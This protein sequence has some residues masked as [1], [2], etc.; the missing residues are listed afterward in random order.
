MNTDS[1]ALEPYALEPIGVPV[2]F[3]GVPSLAGG[4]R[5]LYGE[6]LDPF[7][8]PNSGGLFVFDTVADD[9][10]A[11]LPDERHA[12]FRNV[13]VHEDSAM[14]A[15][16]DGS[17]LRYEPGATTLRP[18]GISLGDRL[19]AS[20]RPDSSGII[21]AVTTSQHDLVA[22]D[23]DG[24]VR[25][26]GNA[27]AYSTSIALLPDQSAFIYVPDAHGGTANFGAP[28]IAV[29][30]S[31]GVQTTL[32]ELDQLARDG[33]GLV[34]GGSFN[35]TVDPTRRLAH[36]GLNAGPTQESPWG[37]VVQITV[38]LDNQLAD[39]PA[40]NAAA[41]SLEAATDTFGL[42]APLTGIRGHAV[43]VADIN[44]D[45]W[46]D[47]FVGTFA[48]RPPE[49]YAVRGAQGPNPDRLLLGGPDGF[50]LDDTFPG[51]LARSA[52]AAF[53]DLDGDGD[54]DVIS[55][56]LGDDKVAWYSN[57]AGQFGP[58]QIITLN[59]DLV[60]SV[61][62]A[63]V[64]ADG[65][66]DVISVSALDDKVA[67]YQGNGAGSFGPEQIISTNPDYPVA[68]TTADLDGDLDP[69]VITASTGDDTLAWFENET[70]FPD[71]N[72]NGVNDIVEIYEGDEEDCNGNLVPDSCELATGAALDCNGNGIPDE[73]EIA[74]G[75]LRDC[76]GNGIPDE[77][78]IAAG[79]APDCNGNGFVD[80]C[81]VAAGVETD[82]DG[83][84]VLD[85]CELAAGIAS[86]CN[87]NG[88]LD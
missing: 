46:D 83:N 71:C 84:G 25:S 50:R 74:A 72:N 85:S 68:L 22:I 29:D 8:N 27:V 70:P 61:E 75:V 33:L 24:N 42:T 65:S 54:L 7:S 18:T 10:I 40:A 49:T 39:R 44:A 62:A 15:A 16:S 35:V 13:I 43:A 87:G 5:Y 6:A 58:Q 38:E 82:C 64:D 59:A 57:T 4:G 60:E 23:P 26:L 14:V 9:V 34:L 19:R 76:N 69:D 20:T 80:S 77:C 45:G 88:I 31:T 47:L 79:T 12:Q 28:V 1:H 52:G 73:C 67:W 51:R 55:A 21:Y 48:D 11:W 3:H 37:E 53:A 41:S 63:D 78:E 66:L 56:S 17:L 32:V 86:D 2:P 81:E 36:I 30:T